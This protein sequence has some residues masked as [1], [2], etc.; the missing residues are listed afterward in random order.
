MKKAKQISVVLVI[1][2]SISLAFSGCQEHSSDAPSS[3]NSTSMISNYYEITSQPTSEE[4]EKFMEEL[5]EADRL[6]HLLTEYTVEL[7]KDVYPVGTEIITLNINNIGPGSF[8]FEGSGVIDKL[9]GNRWVNV[10]PPASEFEIINPVGTSPSLPGEYTLNHSISELTEPG[11]Y[12]IFVTFYN[13]SMNE[14]QRF[15]FT[16]E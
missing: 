10:K 6:C 13:F 4:F 1:I 3:D 7:E 14:Q 8:Y 11:V 2:I 15:E 16:L 9:D 5:E 12:R